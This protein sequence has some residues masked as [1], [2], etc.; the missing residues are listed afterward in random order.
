MAD[1]PVIRLDMPIV[2]LDVPTRLKEVGVRILLKILMSIY[3]PAGQGPWIHPPVI[4]NF[5]IEATDSLTAAYYADGTHG[6]I[7]VAI[8][9][10][11]SFKKCWR[12][13]KGT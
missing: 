2:R 5:F 6:Y 8:H 7:K 4:S 11:G 13:C 10:N 1:V 9:I 12:Q 3:L